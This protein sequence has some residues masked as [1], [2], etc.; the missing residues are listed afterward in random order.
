M[1]KLLLIL[2]VVVVVAPASASAISPAAT[3]HKWPCPVQQAQ[4]AAAGY[5]PVDASTV[6]GP[7]EGSFFSPGQRSGLLP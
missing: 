5:E 7:V 1:L 3:G 2:L 6:S 4:F